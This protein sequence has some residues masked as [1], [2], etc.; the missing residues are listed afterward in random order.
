MTTGGRKDT[1]ISE[2][3]KGAVTFEHKRKVPINPI[4]HHKDYYQFIH[5]QLKKNHIFPYSA[6]GLSTFFIYCVTPDYSM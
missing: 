6:G 2:A 1:G 5:F 3:K 4:L